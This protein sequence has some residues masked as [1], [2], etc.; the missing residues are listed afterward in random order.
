[1]V[2]AY[3]LEAIF[4]PT[5]TVLQRLGDHREASGAIGAFLS[6]QPPKDASQ[7]VLDSQGVELDG[8]FELGRRR[9]PP[10]E[11]PQIPCGTGW[12]VGPRRRPGDITGVLCGRPRGHQNDE[13]DSSSPLWP[14]SWAPSSTN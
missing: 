1:M 12:H 14:P 4:E 8:D 13:L 2:E 7:V 3:L 10:F 6:Q 5:C 11:R 9:W